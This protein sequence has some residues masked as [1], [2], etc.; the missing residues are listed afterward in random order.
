MSLGARD[1]PVCAAVIQAVAN[2]KGVDPTE[3]PSLG[4]CINPDAL[5]EL[6]DR[7]AED[8][9]SPINISFS[10]SGCTVYVHGSKEIRA[11]TT[12]VEEESDEG[13]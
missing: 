9:T 10:Y 3:L 7:S 6:A 11:V 4:E 1:E 5:N 2:E 13:T 8:S 12:T